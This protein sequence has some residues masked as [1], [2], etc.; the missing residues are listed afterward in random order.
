VD[1]IVWRPDEEN[2]KHEVVPQ[3]IEPRP[4]PKWYCY[5]LS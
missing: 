4:R 2:E 5:P 3:D 1:K